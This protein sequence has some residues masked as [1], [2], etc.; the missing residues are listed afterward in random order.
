MSP[1]NLSIAT[2]IWLLL[3]SVGCKGSSQVTDLE[4]SNTQDVGAFEIANA[5]ANGDRLTAQ[6]CVSRAGSAD[7]ISDRVLH[8]LMNKGYSRIDLEMFSNTG[9][10]T[11]ERRQVSWTPAQGKQI[12][13]A[14]STGENP[15]LTAAQVPTAGQPGRER[16]TEP[17]NSTK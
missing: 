17:T 14:A 16:H 10:G 1:R 9:K 2:C 4:S 12:Q 15:C 3:L 5:H 13:A 6:V 11:T 7:D 8:E